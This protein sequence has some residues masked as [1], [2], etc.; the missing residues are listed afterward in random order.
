MHAQGACDLL[1]QL[2]GFTGTFTAF[3]N[4]ADAC[5]DTCA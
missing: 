3:G 1:D 4:L 5:S 2:V